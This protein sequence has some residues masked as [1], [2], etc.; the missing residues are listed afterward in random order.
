MIRNWKSRGRG[1]VKFAF[2]RLFL[3][4]GS[5]SPFV[6]PLLSLRD[7]TSLSMLSV[8][9]AGFSRLVCVIVCVRMYS[10]PVYLAV[11]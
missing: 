7:D 10:D 6:Q 2:A 3:S 5:F 8:C 9:E 11:F 4:L 1:K